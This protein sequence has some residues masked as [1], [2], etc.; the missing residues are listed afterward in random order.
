MKNALLA[1]FCFAIPAYLLSGFFGLGPY[2]DM[3][4]PIQFIIKIILL[5]G[6]IF[7]LVE[8]WRSKEITTDDKLFWTIGILFV[9]PIGLPL[10][11]LKKLSN[12]KE[13][14]SESNPKMKADD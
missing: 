7:I 8:F 12:Q 10:L 1:F 6:F 11:Y 9:V 5:F 3:L 2:F 14:Q 13:M 4:G